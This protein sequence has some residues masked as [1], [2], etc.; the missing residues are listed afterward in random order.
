MVLVFKNAGEGLLLKTAAL[1]VFFL[2]NNTIVDR[3]EKCDLFSE[4]QYSFRSSRSAAFL[5]TVLS[6]I[7]A[8]TLNRCGTT[9]VV[10]LDISKAFDS[11]NVSYG[12]SSQIFDLISN[13]LSNRRLRLVLDGKSSQKYPVNAGILHDP[14]LMTFLMMLSVLLLSMLMILLSTLNVIKHLICGN[15]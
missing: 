7:I 4:F 11:T 15:N 2:V 13:F 6:D 1:L 5:L 12:I 14:I 9:R 10:A 3:L 8:R